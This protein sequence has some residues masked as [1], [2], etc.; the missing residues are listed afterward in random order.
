MPKT[1]VTKRS[2][3]TKEEEVFQV[4]EI[5]NKRVI[6]GVVEYYLKWKGYG[7]ADNTWEPENNLDCPE[8]IAEFERRHK[9]QKCLWGCAMVEGGVFVML[10]RCL[11]V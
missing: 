3:K 1:K 4:E 6:S 7:E 9:V 2:R 5:V 8:L 11:L 10:L